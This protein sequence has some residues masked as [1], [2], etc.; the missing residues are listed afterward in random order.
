M[1]VRIELRCVGRQKV[2]MEPWMFPKKLL[3]LCGA[4]RETSVPEEHN[5][6]TDLMQ[7][8]VEKFHHLRGPDILLGME[9]TA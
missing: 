3:Y 4:V 2:G 8:M 5:R 6:A 1:F 9:S 7:Q